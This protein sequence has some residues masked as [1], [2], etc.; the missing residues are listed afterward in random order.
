MANVNHKPFAKLKN[1]K[2]TWGRIRNTALT[3][4]L[5]VA[6]MGEAIT[7]VNQSPEEV[8]NI[9]SAPPPTAGDSLP[10]QFEP[11]PDTPL[12]SVLIR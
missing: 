1:L 6:G 11:A 9:A 4:A 2:M 12:P 8:Q 5:L 10:H 3:A 7:I